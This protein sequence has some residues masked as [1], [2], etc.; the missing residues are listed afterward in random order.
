MLISTKSCSSWSGHKETPVA[1]IES[2]MRFQ[3]KWKSQKIRHVL[4][5]HEVSCFVGIE[6]LTKFSEVGVSNMT[7]IQCKYF[8]FQC[9]IVYECYELIF[10]LYKYYNTA[11]DVRIEAKI[12]GIRMPTTGPTT[13][14]TTTRHDRPKSCKKSCVRTTVVHLTLICIFLNRPLERGFSKKG[15]HMRAFTGT[16]VERQ[17]YLWYASRRCFPQV[18]KAF[19]ARIPS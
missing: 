19:M 18:L 7:H 15:G 1:Q 8:K 2:K 17:K 6:K 10:F 4:Q 11:L 9:P 13:Q 5:T 14:M 3:P 12:Y 16:H